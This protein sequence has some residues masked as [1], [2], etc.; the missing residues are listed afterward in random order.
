MR[1]CVNSIFTPTLAPASKR[2]KC[3]REG[4]VTSLVVGPDSPPFPSSRHRQCSVRDPWPSLRDNLSG[5]GGPP[6]APPVRPLRGRESAARSPGPLR[7]IS[8]LSSHARTPQAR[9]PAF[10]FPYL[11][12]SSAVTCRTSLHLTHASKHGEC[13]RPAPRSTSL[14]GRFTSRDPRAGPENLPPTTPGEPAAWI[15]VRPSERTRPG[16]RLLQGPDLR[17]VHPRL[18]GITP[19]RG[20]GRV[21]T[22]VLDCAY[23]PPPTAGRASSAATLVACVQA[24]QRGTEPD[25][26]QHG[27]R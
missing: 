26:V 5:G 22:V 24:G 21:P 8:A 15:V 17:D 13:G 2:D 3:T 25:A 18:L 12:A 1:A 7:L 23:A 20:T 9:G 6:D 16:G 27:H 10:C 4:A 11:G 19:D 14:G